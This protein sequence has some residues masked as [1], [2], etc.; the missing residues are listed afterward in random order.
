MFSQQ[1]IHCPGGSTEEIRSVPGEDVLPFQQ[2]EEDLVDKLGG[3]PGVLRALTRHPAVGHPPK[4]FV[5]VH[6]QLV[7]GL[8]VAVRHLR[9]KPRHLP[10]GFGSHGCT[11]SI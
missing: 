4:L 7:L 8:F 3:P 9:K 1:F 11:P 2:T 5:D 10:L 6:Q